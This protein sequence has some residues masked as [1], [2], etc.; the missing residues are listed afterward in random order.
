[1]FAEELAL[2]ESKVYTYVAENRV[3]LE[4]FFVVYDRLRHR[5]ITR[6]QFFRA[7]NA[8]M[9]NTLILSVGEEAAVV[10]KYGRT[11]GMINYR[12]FCDVC[13]GIQRDLEK[14]PWTAVKGEFT[15]NHQRRNQL[16]PTD[17][18]Y[19]QAMLLPMLQQIAREQGLIV[20]NAYSDFDGNK[21]GCVTKNQFLRGLPDKFQIACSKSDIAILVDRYSLPDAYG[22]GVDVSYHTMHL[23]ISGE[24]PALTL[25]D[26]RPDDVVHPKPSARIPV[27]SQLERSV[28]QVCR[29]RQFN[30]EPFFLDFDKLRTGFVS[31]KVF[32]RVLCT[33]GL[34]YLQQ[35]TE[36]LAVLYQSD[37]HK[38]KWVDYRAFA[39]EM[40]TPTSSVRSVLQDLF[41]RSRRE[42]ST[43]GS[44]G[45]LGLLAALRAADLP[46]NGRYA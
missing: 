25:P 22:T 34:E 15:N 39:Q 1:M 11:D 33:L 10:D 20:K 30:M 6:S 2:V 44:A 4:S 14:A 13:T 36:V 41:E 18:K 45:L 42:F 3:R 27:L 31:P 21:N 38:D 5:H 12:T 29:D 46:R 19:F 9:N 37:K 16:S 17:E 32:S 28:R 24:D 35:D 26:G 43:R 23:D 40:E 8:A 7:L